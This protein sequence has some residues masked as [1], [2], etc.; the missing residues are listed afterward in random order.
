MGF[1]LEKLS[2]GDRQVIAAGLFVVRTTSQDRGEQHGLCPFHEESNPS[3][4]YNFKKD[5]YFCQT[6]DARGD[7]I[8]LWGHAKGVPESEQF[9]EFC[10]AHNIEMGK[11]RPA[12]GHGRRK[13]YAPR[14]TAPDNYTGSSD[15][16]KEQPPVI[17]E[18]AWARM[19]PLPDAM[20][21][22]LL[23]KRG[24]TDQVM[25]AMDL[26]L[27]TVYMDKSGRI[28]DVSR[29]ERIAMP[30]RDDDG[31]LRNIR[32][33]K[34]GA[35][36][37]KITS[38]G[39]GYGSSRLYPAG[40]GLASGTVYLCEGEP[41]TLCARSRGLNAIT[42]TSK[43]TTWSDDQRRHIK[44]RDVIICYDADRAGVEY[45][46]KAAAAI[47][48][49]AKSV[50]I[51]EWPEYMGRQADG[52]WPDK[53]GQDLTD[54]FVTHGRTINEFQEL[55]AAARHYEPP[56]KSAEE[57]TGGAQFFRKGAS[58]RWT[59][60]PRW[61]ADQIIKDIPLMYHPATSLLYKWNGRHWE[62]YHEDNL[63]KL[64]ISYLGDSAKM[65]RVSDS[66]S[67]ARLLSTIQHGREPNDMTDWL[68]LQNVMLDISNLDGERFTTRPHDRDFYA[69]YSLNVSLEDKVVPCDRWLQFLDETIQTT[70]AIMQAQEFAGYC[71]TRETRYG[72]C[73]FLLG[74]GADGKST[75]L[76]I[77]RKLVGEQ[78]CAAVAFRDMEDQFYRSALYNKL[79]NISTE[80]GSAAMES[81]Y[82]K[83][84]CTGDAISAA[85]KNKTPFEFEPFCKLAFAAN[86]LPRVKDNSDGFFR[87]VLPISFKRQFFGDADDKWLESKLEAELSGIFQWALAGLYRLRKQ[88]G[89]TWCDETDEL[90]QDYKRE[91]NP[92]L[93]FVED[94]CVVAAG[95][96]VQKDGLYKSYVDYC[97]RSGYREY[98]KVHFFRELAIVRKGLRETKPR[99][100]GDRVRYLEGIGLRAKDLG[101]E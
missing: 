64:A 11:D 54:F 40:S 66:T 98:S 83:A 33:Y 96:E 23:E 85:F 84:I 14:S 58:G 52:N 32:C 56:A 15:H 78:N 75:F 49:D 3:F 89:F 79:L 63:K 51:L 57:P 95:C 68:C 81:M 17:D 73:L 59:F 21:R 28:I 100:A 41:D 60:V 43:T 93:C 61:L 22:M 45:A 82:F 44:G 72:K 86:K 12:K 4:S 6:C 20:R 38:W 88:N 34:P 8:S 1:C 9:K 65:N 62:E 76:K 5:V 48:D 97:K 27:Q 13:D 55:V 10:R 53:H 47:C 18:A 92:V 19:Q 91:N 35:K 71:L 50:R 30:V 90:L 29:A 87:R 67:Q 24:W 39:A 74:P 70:E 25:D 80:V 31:R 77:L 101:D 94:E 16:G 37:N 7:L 2:A 42:Q 36:V 99:K 26:R 46:E 69:T